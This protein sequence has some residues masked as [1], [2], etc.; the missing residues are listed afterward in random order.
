VTAYP[1]T[2]SWHIRSDK[3]TVLGNIPGSMVEEPCHWRRC[4]QDERLQTT[5][6]ALTTSWPSSSK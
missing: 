6:G 5:Q 2:A 1:L 3:P 4:D